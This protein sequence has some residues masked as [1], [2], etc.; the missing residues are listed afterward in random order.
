MGPGGLDP[1]E[2]FSTLP[3]EMQ[4][5]FETKDMDLLKKALT[6]MTP[7]KQRLV[8]AEHWILINKKQKIFSDLLEGRK[9]L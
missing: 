6:S 3:E 7:Q 8:K 4:M 1:V 5:A 2:V 9:F